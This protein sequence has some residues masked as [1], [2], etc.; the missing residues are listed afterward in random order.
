LSRWSIPADH[1]L[2]LGDVLSAI[3]VELPRILGLSRTALEGT[4]KGYNPVLFA[5]FAGAAGI[6]FGL[7]AASWKLGAGLT[8]SSRRVT[9]RT[10][11]SC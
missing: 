10:G 9:S 5:S 11:K 4:A 6:A 3:V 7:A 2:K 1:R 8:S